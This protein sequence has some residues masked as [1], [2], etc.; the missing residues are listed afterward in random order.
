MGGGCSYLFPGLYE[1]TWRDVEVILR[2]HI[3]YY[4]VP[5][6]RVSK[7]PLVKNNSL[8]LLDS[9]ERQYNLAHMV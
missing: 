9:P 5:G 2:Q 7:Y 4:K 1:A 8:I 6:R 3:P